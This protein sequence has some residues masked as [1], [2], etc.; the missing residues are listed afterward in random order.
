MFMQTTSWRCHK[1]PENST[2]KDER[3]LFCV[4]MGKFNVHQF[5]KVTGFFDDSS[6]KKQLAAIG[7]GLFRNGKDR[8]SW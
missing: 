3:V 8:N 6:V 4:F 7:D 5:L 2:R 1:H